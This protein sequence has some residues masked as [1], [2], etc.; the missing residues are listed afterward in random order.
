LELSGKFHGYFS[1]AYE[2]LAL[3]VLSNTLLGKANNRR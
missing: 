2:K 1:V 3:A